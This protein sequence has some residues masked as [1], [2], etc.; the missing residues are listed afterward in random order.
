MWVSTFRSWTSR[1]WRR[2]RT[3]NGVV[4]TSSCICKLFFMMA[5]LD[6]ILMFYFKLFRSDFVWFATLVEFFEEWRSWRFSVYLWCS[7]VLKSVDTLVVQNSLGRHQIFVQVASLTVMELSVMQHLVSKVN[8]VIDSNQ[9][10]DLGV[11]SEMI[12]DVDLCLFGSS[13]VLALCWHFYI[14]W[15]FKI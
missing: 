5:S 4:T 6:D 8:Q 10:C 3:S 13:S 7:V 1:K 2:G 15:I 14:S 9:I 11:S 12:A